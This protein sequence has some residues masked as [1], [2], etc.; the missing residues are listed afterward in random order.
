MN[1]GRISIIGG[2]VTGL[3]AAHHL[4]ERGHSDFTLFEASP[5]AGGI[6]STR[7]VD[8]LVL[9][10]G[11][12]S[13]ITDKPEALDLVRRLGLADEVRGTRTESRRS[14]VVRND[15]LVPTPDGFY[16]IAPSRMGPVWSSPLFSPLGKLRIALEPWVPRR[17]ATGDESLAS[18]VQRRLGGEVLERVAQAMVGGIYGAAPE[19]LSLAATFPR[20]LALEQEYGS[21]IRGLAHG[22]ANAAAAS[23]P[24]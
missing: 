18:F 7:R 3:A 19:E 17:K 13:F 22:R 2:G 23:G 24:R 21:V 12:D 6:V 9:E 20:F 11:P 16:L 14:F 4:T 5:R 1:P 15:R 10:E 8:G